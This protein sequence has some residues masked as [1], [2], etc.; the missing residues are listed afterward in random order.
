VWW[1]G[2][3]QEEREGGREGCEQRLREKVRTN[4]EKH[5]KTLQ[6]TA[7]LCTNLKTGK[8]NCGNSFKRQRARKGE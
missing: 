2:L 4:S 7:T 3:G 6:H 5:C 1:E 8:P